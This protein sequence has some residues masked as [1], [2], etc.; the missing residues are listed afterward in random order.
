[1]PR[2]LAP[3][4]CQILIIIRLKSNS[5]SFAR[6][7]RRSGHAALAKIEPQLRL[8]LWPQIGW[9]SIEIQLEFGHDLVGLRVRLDRGRIAAEIRPIDSVMS[10]NAAEKKGIYCS[11][12]VFAHRRAN[13]RRLGY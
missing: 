3:R 10:K 13:T 4:F 2:P 7:A 12:W 6:A 5:I 8:R 1:M 11:F 9:I